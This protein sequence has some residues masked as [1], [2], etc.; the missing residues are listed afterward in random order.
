MWYAVWVRTGQEEKVP[1]MC[2]KMLLEQCFLPRY[3][4]AR[5]Q[6]GKWIKVEKPLFP[7]CLFLSVIM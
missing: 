6:Y 5:K 3:E 7:G 2:K 1:Q 4:R